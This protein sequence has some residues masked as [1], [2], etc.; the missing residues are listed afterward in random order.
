MLVHVEICSIVIIF[1]YRL[2]IHGSRE[3]CRERAEPY[4]L[5]PPA[6]AGL[7]LRLCLSGKKLN[8]KSPT[9]DL[10]IGLTPTVI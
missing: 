4:Y 9:Y 2:H 6:R 10:E 3:R 7:L 5:M 1:S 8:S